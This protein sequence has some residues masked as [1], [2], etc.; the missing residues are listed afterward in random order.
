MEKV[1]EGLRVVDFTTNI[2]GPFTTAFMADFGAEVIKIEKPKSG[3]DTRFFS[4][5]VDGVGVPFCWNNRGKKSLVLDMSD[6][7][8][9]EIVK[10]LIPSTDVIVESF[11][12][13]TMKKFGLD[14]DTVKKINPKVVFCSVSGF[15]Q[16][17]PYSNKAGY[18]LI[19]QALSGAMDMTG[20]KE[21]P[22]VR[23]GLAVADYNAGIHAFAGILAAL[24]HRERTGEGQAVDISLLDCLV[25]INGSVEIAGVGRNITRSGNHHGAL[26]PFGIYQGTG[27]SLIVCAPAQ[28]PWKSLCELMGRLDM[29]EDPLFS[30]TGARVKNINKLVPVIEAWLKSF[31]DTEQPFKLMDKAGIPCAKVNTTTQALENEQLLAREMVIELETPD[32]VSAK[33]IKAR[34]NPIK[35]STLKAEQKKAPAL[36]QHEDEVLKSLGYDDATLARLKNKWSIA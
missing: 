20:E 36:G 17:G 1:F 4:P 30:N 16:T 12:P 25:A 8:A 11:K 26:A 18:D 33:T 35:F 5:Q 23:I 6:P 19:A 22:P 10:K 15:G 21:G 32:G 34:G 3:D 9:I 14:Y 13:G 2:A 28:G 24:Y 27:G 29:Y 31:P 7:E